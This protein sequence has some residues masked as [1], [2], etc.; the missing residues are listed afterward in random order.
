VN[1]NPRS[2]AGLRC[3]GIAFRSLSVASLCLGIFVNSLQ[4]QS[5]NYILGTTNL[6]EGPAAGGD[7]VVL[8]TSPPTASWTATTTDSWLHLSPAN[9]GGTGSTNV[10]FSFDANS[11]ATRLGTLTIGNQTLTVTQ[12]GFTYVAAN[13]WSDF[14]NSSL[15]IGSQGVAIDAAGNIYFADTCS[16]LIREWIPSLNVV[17]NLASLGFDYPGGIALDNAGNVYITDWGNNAIKE[18]VASSNIVITLVSSGLKYPGGLAVDGLGN[19]YIADSGNHAIKEWVA[20]SNAVI[21]LVSSG[22]NEPEGVAL[23]VA[24]NVY[25]ADVGNSVKEW[26]AANKALITLTNVGEPAGVAVDGGGNVYIASVYSVLEYK[27]S[28]GSLVTLPPPFLSEHRPYSVALDKGGNLYV[29]SLMSHPFITIPFGFVDP[30]PKSEGV[31]AGNDTLP[32][33]LPA[34]YSLMP[35]FAPT[36]DQ[37]WL[38]ITGVTNGMV[39]YSFTANNF[40]SNRTAH[41]SLLGESI[42]ITQSGPPTLTATTILGN[43]AFQFAFSNAPNASFS[44]ISS[45]NVALP[46]SNWTVIGIPSNIGSG[47]FQFTTQTATNEPQRFYRVRSP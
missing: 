45:T 14:T 8:A 23:D 35:P 15:C 19:V 40:M 11:G 46:M 32:V 39:N 24:G 13:S 30:S 27:P 12:A 25:I 7:S 1:I 28:S 10:I 9:Q 20:S 47:I 2:F 38:T 42:P 22:L 5:T 29:Y 44:V 37:S 18:W 36:S 41:I 16:N 3:I 17:S 4:G 43:G 21:T 6:C 34:A 26:I 31:S 33:V